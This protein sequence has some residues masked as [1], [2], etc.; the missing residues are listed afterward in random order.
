LQNRESFVLVQMSF[1]GIHYQ[2]IL[3]VFWLRALA[4]LQSKVSVVSKP[5]LWIKTLLYLRYTKAIVV[6][7]ARFCTSEAAAVGLGP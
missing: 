1:A 4:C 7:F 6:L 2:L 5:Q 3:I